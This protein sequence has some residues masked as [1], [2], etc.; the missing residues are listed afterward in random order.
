[1]HWFRHI[2]LAIQLGLVGIFESYPHD[3][4][5]SYCNTIVLL[6]GIEINFVIKWSIIIIFVSNLSCSVYIFFD[7][8]LHNSSSQFLSFACRSMVHKFNITDVDT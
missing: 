3:L 8:P 7:I 5:S 4:N 1:M 6:Q 2:E